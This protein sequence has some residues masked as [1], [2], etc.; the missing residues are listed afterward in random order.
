MAIEPRHI[1]EALTNVNADTPLETLMEQLYA[2][3][4]KCVQRAVGTLQYAQLEPQY[5]GIRTRLMDEFGFDVHQH[6]RN[7]TL[8]IMQRPR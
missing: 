6:I 7:Q 2:Q 5:K 1:I 4:P 8:K 3:L